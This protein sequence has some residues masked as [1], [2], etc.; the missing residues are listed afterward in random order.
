MTPPISLLKARTALAAGALFL[1][2][3]PVYAET[4][5]E[6]GPFSLSGTTRWRYEA[7]DGQFRAGFGGSDQAISGRTLIQA[8]YDA[9][10]WV[11][12]GE[13]IDSR[14]Y[15]D[16]DGSPLST[17]M[18]NTVDILQAYIRRPFTLNGAPAQLQAGR[19]TLNVGSRRFMARNGFRNTINAFTGVNFTAENIAGWRVTAFH[20]S[21]VRRYPRDF[22]ALQDNKQDFDEE[23]WDQR[24]WGLH[25]RRENLFGETALEL[26]LFGLTEGDSAGLQTAD[27]DQLTPGVRL[28]RAPAPGRWDHDI[29]HAIQF[30]ARS[31]STAP[32]APELDVFSQTHHAEI[33][34][35]WDHPWRP[36]L[37][38]GFEYAGG[39]EAG[40]GDWSRWD[41]QYG[42]RRRDFGQTGIHGPLRRQ[43]IIAPGA[44]LTFGKGRLDGRLL[45]KSAFLAQNT[46]RWASG[47]VVD[48]SGASGDHIG[49]HFD[50]RLRYWA[51]P[52]RLRLETG[53]A[54]FRAGEF[55]TDAPNANGFGDSLF[56]YVMATVHF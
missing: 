7:L 53:G 18:V 28:Y 33:G 44:R 22:T 30:G 27:R 46:D 39:E 9:G 29:E 34:Y 54:W 40:D 20:V 41:I 6:E 3:S 21:P 47:G 14:V 56:G 52:D 25:G 48:P 42:L 43:N 32:G 4:S 15:L 35:T 51:V 38:A 55:A 11:F 26:F 37:S 12:G 1:S 13:L 10:G 49:D 23:N 45:W 24:F 2:A 16:D 19:F 17:S 50:Y 8:E 31:A 36:R 5:G